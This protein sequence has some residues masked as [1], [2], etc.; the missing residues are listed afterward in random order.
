[1]K[2][3]RIVGLIGTHEVCRYSIIPRREM[4]RREVLDGVWNHYPHLKADTAR[5]YINGVPATREEMG[6]AL[7]NVGEE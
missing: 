3:I 6:Q 5:V 1:M 4:D 2:P 7:I